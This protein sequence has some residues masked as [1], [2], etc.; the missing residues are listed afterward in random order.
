MRSFSVH[1]SAAKKH[2][3]AMLLIEQALISAMQASHSEPALS[4]TLEGSLK[5]LSSLLER[6]FGLQLQ[7]E[8][9][10]EGK[11]HENPILQC[12]EGCWCFC[13]AWSWTVIFQAPNAF[14]SEPLVLAWLC[15]SHC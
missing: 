11:Y 5:G 9:I 3:E 6:T 14:L 10:A 13:L 15:D 12:K 1:Q 7:Q 8:P 4:L 2:T